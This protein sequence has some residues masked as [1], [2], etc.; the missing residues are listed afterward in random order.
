MNH[1]FSHYWIGT[2]A[3]VLAL[4]YTTSAHAQSKSVKKKLQLI[5]VMP[6]DS[7]DDRGLYKLKLYN[8]REETALA[9]DHLGRAEVGY[10]LALYYEMQRVPEL[11][12]EE[13]TDTETILRELPVSQRSLEI[14]QMIAEYYQRNGETWKA[15]RMFL[16]VQEQE[17]RLSKHADQ[18]KSAAGILFFLALFSMVYWGRQ[19]YLRR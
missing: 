13:L 12:I 5:D 9:E 6:M 10:R 17:L 8:L 7:P 11:G 1:S 18:Q 15:K 4:T 16:L 3:C 19:A 2:F 14:S